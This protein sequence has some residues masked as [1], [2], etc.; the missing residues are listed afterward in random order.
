[1][2]HCHASFIFFMQI[3]LYSDVF[4]SVSPD[5]K[6]VVSGQF[7]GPVLVLDSSTVTVLSSSG[8]IIREKSRWNLNIGQVSCYT[9]NNAM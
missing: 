9:I 5:S 8:E 1:M 3:E 4:K 6:L 2:S 7:G